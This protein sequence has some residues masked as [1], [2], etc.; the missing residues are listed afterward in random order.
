MGLLLLQ[1]ISSLLTFQKM[2]LLLE[3]LDQVTG[4]SFATFLATPAALQLVPVNLVM[5]LAL[6]IVDSEELDQFYARLWPQ[7]H[8]SPL[9]LLLPAKSVHTNFENQYHILSL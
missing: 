6:G 8:V 5:M 4:P 1:P 9:L 2:L 3:R 7:Q